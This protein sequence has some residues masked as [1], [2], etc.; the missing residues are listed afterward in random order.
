MSRN[1]S[2]RYFGS[3]SA[4]AVATVQ[5]AASTDGAKAKVP[6]SGGP[7]HSTVHAATVEY[8][9]LDG[10]LEDEKAAS[11]LESWNKIE[12]GLKTQ[13]LHLFAETYGRVQ[14]LSAENVEALKVFF[15]DCLGRGKLLKNKE[16]VYNRAT[17]AVENVPS[18]AI[19]PG[20][21][22]F[23]LR[24]MDKSRVSTLKS[25]TPKRV[26]ATPSGEASAKDNAE[27]QRGAAK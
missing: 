23:T 11:R 3:T 8:S 17:G 1:F 2:N 14:G 4:A 10:I 16:V 24:N 25:L 19:H 13:K 6:G 5:A 18:L 15:C 22:A 20:T 7:A 12:C 9:F 21:R 26:I 27:H